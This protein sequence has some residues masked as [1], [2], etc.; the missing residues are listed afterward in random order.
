M[1]WEHYLVC[2]Q[3]ILFTNSFKF[4]VFQY[5]VSG[6]DNWNESELFNSLGPE[7]LPTFDFTGL[8]MPQIYQAAR[9]PP[10]PQPFQ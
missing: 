2:L 10:M 9:A 4:C 7:T 1:T 6:V 8:Q 3:I 5:F